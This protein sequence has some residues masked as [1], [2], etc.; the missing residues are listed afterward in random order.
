MTKCSDE[1]LTR[2]GH[3]RVRKG[4]TQD[5]QDLRKT[6]VDAAH[7]LFEE[8]GLEAITVRNLAQRAKVACMTPYKYF[9][10]KAEILLHLKN[11]VLRDVLCHISG[12]IEDF[13]SAEQRM[14]GLIASYLR[15][16]VGNPQHYKLMYFQHSANGKESNDI[17][18][19]SAETYNLRRFH[20][21]A[22]A[23]YASSC[24]LPGTNV[25]LA[26]SFQHV[27][28]IGFAHML[29]L[30][31][32]MFADVES[33]IAGQAKVLTAA[34]LPILAQ[35]FNEPHFAEIAKLL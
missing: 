1:N 32:N 4:N 34:T 31:S 19:N 3:R 14:E 7:E 27:S 29:I 17:V 8:G 16:W 12:S 24:N 26:A 10:N 2:L 33:A 5:A 11:D 25:K 22:V 30:N 20:I 9:A 18:F 6:L 23:E 13:A 21:K 35:S 28:S 15:Y